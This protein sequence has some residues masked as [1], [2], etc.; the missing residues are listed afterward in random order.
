MSGTL[1]FSPWPNGASAA[2]AIT[3]DVDA[4][5]G[6]L[7][8]GEEYRRRLTTLSEARFGITRGVPRILELLGALDVPATFY[9]P[10]ETAERHGAAL[11]AAVEAGHEVGHHGHRHL[12][13]DKVGAAAQREEIERGLEAL[14]RTFGLRPRGYRSA[15]WEITPETFS[16]L[17]EFGFDYDSSF[18]GDDR[19][20]WEEHDGNRMLEFPV[21]WSLDDWPY[22]AWSIEAGGNLAPP[23]A[24]LDVWLREL[25]SVIEDGRLMTLTMH[26]EVI[27]RGHRIG[28]LASFIAAARERAQVWFASHGQIADHLGVR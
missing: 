6:W 24:V 4:E 5:A 16:L 27:G 17:G 8:E 7:A 9:V 22:F 19:P 13:S 23:A 12:R 2:V 3:F 20:Y 15:S 28:V 21:H 18:M 25:D 10:G 1:A 11:L 14:E 26:P